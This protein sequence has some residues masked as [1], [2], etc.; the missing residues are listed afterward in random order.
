MMT[1]ASA[2]PLLPAAQSSSSAPREQSGPFVAKRHAGGP[3]LY[4][5]TEQARACAA[6]A[7]GASG[8][9]EAWQG[10]LTAAEQL[11]TDPLIPEAEALGGVGQH[12]RIF[13]ASRQCSSVGFALGLAFHATGDRRYAERIRE[14]LLHYATYREW[15]GPGFATRRP[16]WNSEL[17]TA[18]F[19]FGFATGYDA[20]ADLL[21]TDERRRIR[22]ALL[23]RGIQP[24]LDDWVL[25]G[26]RIHALDSMGH[27]WWSVCVGMA[28]VGLLA[29]VE[30][31]P[32]AAEWLGAV[33]ASL[34]EWFAYSG[35]PLQNKPANFDP[36][37]GLYEGVHYT[38]YGVAEYLRFRLA[39]ENIF[40]AP[41]FEDGLRLEDTVRFALHTLY[42]ARDGAMTVNFG[43]SDLRRSFARETMRLIRACGIQTDAVDWYLSQIEKPGP[44]GGTSPRDTFRLL[45][46]AGR[47]DRP[48]ADVPAS[49]AFTGIGW[50]MARSSWQPDATLLAVKSG[51]TWNHAHADAGSFI[52]FHRGQPLLI[53][54]GKCAY[55]RAEYMEYYVRSRAHNVVLFDGKGQLEEDQVRG[56]KFPGSVQR[57]LDG[58]GIRLVS[59]DA[60]GP[61]AHVFSRNYRHWLWIGEVI[62]MIDDIRAHREGRFDWLLHYAGSAEADESGARIVNAAAAARI[63]FLHSPLLHRNVECGLADNQPDVQRPFLRFSTSTPAREAKLFTAIVLEAPDQAKPQI[64]QLAGNDC[65]GVRITQAG[66]TTEVWLNL[67]ADGR[68]AHVNSINECGGWTTDAYLLASTRRTH[69]FEATDD[70]DSL[71]IV[72]GSMVQRDRPV[73]SSLS[74]TTVLLNREALRRGA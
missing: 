10:F 56:V 5:T 18:A 27:N 23:D 24:L 28:G 7:A 55:D 11:L 74:K 13:A 63:V 60:T 73:W 35:N 68:V 65:L 47:S 61:M 69:V 9:G 57:V 25:P 33:R 4:Y 8:A 14:T 67:M 70:L 64:E 50:A 43:D 21:A 16:R 62:L 12:G 46:P 42:P 15:T 38:E 3:R 31:E 39:H 54:S 72:D 29:V 51:Y 36:A 37:G 52:L 59:A 58:E 19:T 66:R 1:Y 22:D 53:D 6:N 44:P 49:F 20:I 30:E 71:L 34:G 40:A 45:Y 26:R 17:A 2:A 32:R 41:P 48:P